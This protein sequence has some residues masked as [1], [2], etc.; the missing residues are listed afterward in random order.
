MFQITNIEAMLNKMNNLKMAKVL[1]KYPK[2]TWKIFIPVYNQRKI[3]CNNMEMIYYTCKSAKNIFNDNDC[4]LY[5]KLYNAFG[6]NVFNNHEEIHIID[7]R[8]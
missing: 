1:N 8:A 7:G 6:N 4:V 5:Y 2:S 3:N